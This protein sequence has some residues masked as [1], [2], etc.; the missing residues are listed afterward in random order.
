MGS[1]RVVMLDTKER[2]KAYSYARFSS[3]EQ[4]KG[5]SLRRQ[6][7]AAKRAAEKF[8]LELVADIEDLGRSAFHGNHIKKGNLGELLD[9]IDQNQIPSGAVLLI[10]TFDR[11]SRQ[12]VNEALSIFIRI[13]V[14][15]INIIT[16]M[17][18][19]EYS[20]TDGTEKLFN[21]IMKMGTA[22]DES[23]KKSDRLNKAWAEK[24]SKAATEKLTAKCPSWL[25]L[26]ADRKEFDV[27]EER[28]AIV[29]RIYDMA[30]DGYGAMKIAMTL[31]AEGVPGFGLENNGWHIPYVHKLLAYEAVTGRYVPHS[32]VGS[33]RKPCGDPVE[34]YYPRIVTDEIFNAVQQK[35]AA[36]RH[37]AGGRHGH[38][39]T[40]LFTK[41][42]KCGYCGAT[43][44]FYSTTTKKSRYRYI[45]CR[46]A[47]RGVGC[48]KYAT[49]EMG[50]FEELFF[51]FVSEIDV[52]ALIA[53]GT[54]KTELQTLQIKILGR[55][56]ELEKIET[57][58]NT[59]NDA[60][61]DAVQKGKQA[62][63]DHFEDQ[64][65]DALANR[66]QL[67]NELKNLEQELLVLE[68]S[69]KDIAEC[70]ERSLSLYEQI[71]ENPEDQDF[72]LKV[73]A[74]LRRI[75]KR[76][77]FCAYKHPE[78]D[79]LMPFATIHFKNGAALSFLSPFEDGSGMVAVNY[80]GEEKNDDGEIT[81]YGDLVYRDQQLGEVPVTEY[82]PDG[83]GNLAKNK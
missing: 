67:K 31:N 28:A 56:G 75:I 1:E 58:V 66:D 6:Q 14:K 52:S 42:C 33:K 39:F 49:I 72:R 20:L 83:K 71:K 79:D 76:I 77:D 63:S 34:N 46:D 12:H 43:M 25:K 5:D 68:H 23:K 60:F 21:V 16:T 48:D 35:K 11:L 69:S 29:R 80:V 64:L 38:Q 18:G 44:S 73:N 70:I 54:H 7:E 30:L 3:L 50:Y 65:T 55:R 32:G 78:K 74:E 37:G 53:N 45:A 2:R 27:I 22:H 10:E 81:K 24:K 59:L 47:R 41:L 4:S 26:R 51:K 62:L 15:G 19:Y 17:D 61:L 36:Y 13:L 57:N 9:A 82:E 8:N 40:N